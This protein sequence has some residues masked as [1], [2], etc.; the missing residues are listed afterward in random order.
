MALEELTWSI[1]FIICS[2]AAHLLRNEL[3]KKYNREKEEIDKLK[4]KNSSENFTFRKNINEH[5][6]KS[7]VN[8]LLPTKYIFILFAIIVFVKAII[9]QK[10]QHIVL[11][12]FL[13]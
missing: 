8:M 13:F 1:V 6:L 10:E 11:L 12:F 7:Q 9:N 3:L 5:L 2:F 4:K